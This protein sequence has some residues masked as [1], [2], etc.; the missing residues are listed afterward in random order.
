MSAQP[1]EQ[2]C[3]LKLEGILL[4]SRFKV[5]QLFRCGSFSELYLA[6]NAFPRPGEPENVVV[7]ALN[8]R[9]RG[10]PGAELE[11][12]L[13]KGFQS[14]AHALKQCEHENIVRLLECGAAIANSRGFYYLVLEYL[15]GGNL[16]DLLQR[17]RIDLAVALSLL[18]QITAALSCIH[19]K[20][21]V[22]RDIK[23]ANVMLSLDSRKAKLIDLGTV[24]WLDDNSQVT[25]IGTPTYAAPEH[26]STPRSVGSVT[27]AADV[28]AFA[29]T[30]YALLSGEEPTGLNQQQIT[31]LP[32]SVRLEPWAMPL[33]RVLMKATSDI[34][35]TR[36]QT[37]AEFFRDLL[38]A[39]EVTTYR[40]R[41][42]E[43]NEAA[44]EPARSR[45]VVDVT[46][47]LKE[48]LAARLAS[49]VAWSR[50]VLSYVCLRI[51]DGYLRTRRDLRTV[52][53][54]TYAMVATLSVFS[55][56]TLLLGPGIV[57]LARRLLAARP[58]VIQPQRDQINELLRATTDLNIRESPIGSAEKIGLV[59]NESLVR[60][61]R[62]NGTQ[63]WCEIEMVTH[64]RPK[65]D[66]S[67]SDRGW[68]VCKFL[69]PD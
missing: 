43:Q 21:L 46:P 42:L 18:G 5:R 12:L 29:K 7:K 49:L 55:I 51:I 26:Y 28:Y 24:R 64:G 50:Q 20:G 47:I 61:L 67:F 11:E 56:A 63:K 66:A 4:S 6:H 1:K 25:E 23:P 38:N 3:M 60:V 15:P 16:K 37:V 44:K 62:K 53:G 22:H 65:M 68:V 31:D 40:I 10:E 8:V 34:P 19:Q 36:H 30:C 69:A 58:V 39:T 17:G 32:R 41:D 2:I 33:L 35:A 57:Q 14:E 54:K 13:V 27:V 59:E 48:P 9:L 52:G 45:F